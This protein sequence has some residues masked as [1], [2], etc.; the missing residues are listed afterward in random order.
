MQIDLTP[1]ATTLV[2]CVSFQVST[3]DK[4]SPADNVGHFLAGDK[5][6]SMETDMSEDQNQSWYSSK[7]SLGI[8][9]GI[10]FQTSSTAR[11]DPWLIL[12]IVGM[13]P[14]GLLNPSNILLFSIRNGQCYLI[15]RC[16]V[17]SSW[18]YLFQIAGKFG[19][20]TELSYPFRFNYDNTTPDPRVTDTKGW[21]WTAYN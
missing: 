11:P 10:K 13:Q 4:Y 6:P 15:S 1:L 21:V 16:L 18:L 20:W 3:R 14:G 2:I 12:R 5:A 8:R 9:G 19:N 7:K 17:I